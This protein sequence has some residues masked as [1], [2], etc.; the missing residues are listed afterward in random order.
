[1][2]LFGYDQTVADWAAQKLD[3]AF[4]SLLCAIGYL[5]KNGKLE[6][7]LVM[8]NWS[9]HDCE[10]TFYGKLT[11]GMAKACAFIGFVSSNLERLTVRI[12]RDKKH[13]LKAIVKYGFHCEGTQRRLYGPY[14]RHDAI[15][16]GLLRSE[17]GR[18]LR[19]V[20]HGRSKAA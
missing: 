6:G 20:E 7:A 13:N 19:G 18:L 8:H 17:A 5:D 15:L 16:F 12:P 2:I 10:L 3:C 1:M 9:K 14:K 11:L 4:P